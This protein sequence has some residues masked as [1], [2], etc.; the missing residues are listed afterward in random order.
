MKTKQSLRILRSPIEIGAF[1]AGMALVPRLPRRAVLRLAATLGAA[2][3]RLDR[4]SRSIAKANMRL[5]M[6]EIHEAGREDEMVRK[7]FQTIAL[8]FLD[9]FWFARRPDV[10]LRRYVAFDPSY[11]GV[12][13]NSPLI[14][15]C[16]HF[17]NWE[18]VGQASA[19]AGASAV[20]VAASLRSETLDRWLRRIR[21]RNG[22]RIVARDGAAR[23]LLRALREG[24]RIALLLDQNTRIRE[25][26][27]WTPFFGLPVPV[28]GIVE[29]L[30][31]RTGSPVVPVYGYPEPDGTYRAVAGQLL[32]AEQ[33]GHAPGV[34]TAAVMRD[35]ESRIRERPDLWLW[36]YKRWKYI[37]PETDASQ[38]PFYAK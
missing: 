38:Y 20:S 5:A 11:D 23:H 24:E 16:A 4:R 15:T 25:G 2:A 37:A 30:A 7:A 21:T 35:L 26:A 33:V 36:M 9:V 12:F 27:L 28:S 31:L 3:F 10:R 1:A 8:T 22:L 17:G 6:P 34:L 32:S 18:I 14:A 29:L 13:R 19:L